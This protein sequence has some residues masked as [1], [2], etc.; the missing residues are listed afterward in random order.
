MHLEIIRDTERADA[1]L[2]TLTIGSLVLQTLELPWLPIEG[3]PCGH[4]DQSCVPAGDYGLDLHDSV[5]HPRTFELV[6]P[7]LAVYQLSVPVGTI[8]RCQVLLHNG[9]YPRNS[10]GCILV[11][12]GRSFAN[13]YSMVTNSDVALDAL[14]ALVPWVPGHTLSIVPADA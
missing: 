12:R 4:P 11:G 2:G 7:D 5:L 14:K 8:G 10:L 9:N 1:T 13:G 6:N 3:A